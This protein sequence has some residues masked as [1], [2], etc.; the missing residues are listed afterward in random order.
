[1]KIALVLILYSAVAIAVSI[2]LTLLKKEKQAFMVGITAA[3]SSFV[4][5]IMTIIYLMGGF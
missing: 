5:F 1:M 3:T 2:I 4:S